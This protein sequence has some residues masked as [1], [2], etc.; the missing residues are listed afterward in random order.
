[1]HNVEMPAIYAGI[2]RR[3]ATPAPVSCWRGWAST[4]T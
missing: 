4:G 1:M 2:P 3:N